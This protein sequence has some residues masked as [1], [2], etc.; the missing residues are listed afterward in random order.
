[1]LA[2]SGSDNTIHLRGMASD[3]A[4][5][6]VLTDPPGPWMSLAFSPDGSTLAAGSQ[7]GIIQL[8]D[9]ATGQAIGEPWMDRM[10]KVSSLSFS[11][12]G[13]FLLTNED[14]MLRIWETDT[15][16]VSRAIRTM[17][18]SGTVSYDA[19]WSPDGKTIA[20]G[21]YPFQSGKVVG[22]LDAATG[23]FQSAL[24]GQ[25]CAVWNIAYSPN[26]KLIGAGSNCGT[27]QVWDVKTGV[28]QDQ[29]TFDG[30]GRTVIVVG[31]AF[32]PDGRQ[33]AA[34][35]LTMPDQLTIRLINLETGE[36]MQVNPAQQ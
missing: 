9:S 21:S 15:G 36:T 33:L 25:A 19:I 26:A 27:V 13:K 12:N 23:G 30:Q 28:L 18:L 1:M 6:L 22:L 2:F 5:E 34:Y 14:W 10:Q 4:H 32:S 20:W 29:W 35:D 31:I 8:W 11:P 7:D 17:D 3:T 24:I 16:Q